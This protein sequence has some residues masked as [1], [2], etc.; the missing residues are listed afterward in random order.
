MRQQPLILAIALLGIGWATGGGAAQIL[1]TLFGEVVFNRGP[2]GIG[3]HLGRG[4]LRPDRRRRR[5]APR[6]GRASASAPTSALSPSATSSTAAP[7]SSSAR[8][9]SF[10]WALVF[11]ALSRAAVAVSSVLNMSLL[12]RHVAD[13]YRGRV[14]ATNESLVWATMM[15][16]ML[17]AGLA[18]SHVSPRTIGAWSGALSSL[19]AV[20]WIWAD[21]DRAAGGARGTRD[22]SRRRGGQEEVPA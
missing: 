15:L 6:S 9:R 5:R 2:A 20:Y 10:G 3:I 22:R 13:E 12:L 18:S 19:T 11:I 17:G 4:R 8:C 1:F 21:R 14:F 7:T 16:S